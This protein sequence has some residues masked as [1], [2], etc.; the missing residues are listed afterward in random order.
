M[1]D[2]HIPL[3]TLTYDRHLAVRHHKS[4]KLKPPEVSSRLSSVEALWCWSFKGPTLVLDRARLNVGLREPS[5]SSSIRIAA[6]PVALGLPSTSV[7]AT[8]TAEPGKLASVVKLTTIGSFTA[9]SQ[10]FR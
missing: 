9:L 8:V 6:L 1:I 4:V 3:E 7:Y 2:S 10:L 5:S